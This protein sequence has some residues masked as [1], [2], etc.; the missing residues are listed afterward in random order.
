[1][2]VSHWA[3]VRDTLPKHMRQYIPCGFCGEDDN[4]MSNRPDEEDVQ[5]TLAGEPDKA[6]SAVAVGLAANQ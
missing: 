6:S 4:S 2:K 3:K 5:E 1:M